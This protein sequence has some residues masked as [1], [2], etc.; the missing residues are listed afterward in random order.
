MA[1]AEKLEKFDELQ[2]SRRFNE[3]QLKMLGRMRPDNMMMFGDDNAICAVPYG[4]RR[5]M[6]E[7]MTEYYKKKVLRLTEQIEELEGGKKND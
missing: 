6:L 5:E 7:M 4:M 3:A 2:R 1:D